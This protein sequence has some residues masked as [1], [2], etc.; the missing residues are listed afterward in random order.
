MEE[1][2]DKG[3][4]RFVNVEFW[5]PKKADEKYP[6]LVFS[7]GAYGIKASNTSTYTELA[8]HGYVVVSIDHPYHS[9]YTRQR[10]E[11]WL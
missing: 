6:L 10:M 11:R 5:Y 7:H 9:F 3:R 8:S 4:N 1:F 2:T